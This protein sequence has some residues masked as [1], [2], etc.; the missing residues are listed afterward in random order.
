MEKKVLENFAK[1]IQ[2]KNRSWINGKLEVKNHMT[3]LYVKNDKEVIKITFPF[4]IQSELERLY[5]LAQPASFGKGQESVLDPSYRSARTLLSENFSIN[6]RPDHVL[7]NQIKELMLTNSN[8][9]EYVRAELYRVN[10]YGPGDFFKE[11]K[12]TPQAGS[13]HFGSLVFCLPS[14]FEGGVFAIR[15]LDGNEVKFDWGSTYGSSC[16]ATTMSTTTNPTNDAAAAESV[17]NSTGSSSS[18]SV[19]ANEEISCGIEYLAFASDLD[20]WIEPVTS[21]YRVTVTFHLYK[22]SL[23]EDGLSQSLLGNN[24]IVNSAEIK[25]IKELI[26]SKELKGKRVLFPVVHQYSGRSDSE[27]TLKAGDAALFQVLSNLGLNPKIMFYYDYDE[28]TDERVYPSRKRRRGYASSDDE[29][30]ENHRLTCKCYL[31]DEVDLY[32][33]DGYYEGEDSRPVEGL[34]TSYRVIW[35]RYSALD[36]QSFSVVPS[37]GNEP[38]IATYSGNVCIAT[39]W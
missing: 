9:N 6:L 17:S 37:Y 18:A 33:Y 10:I 23:P 3:T 35:A 12:D 4:P 16:K 31:T 5:N 2:D 14:E 24:N 22:E 39:T 34:A 11:H 15:E 27:V 1:F 8:T 30:D 38:S 36:S 7:L 13:G 28:D 26:A 32:S 29:E 20:H 25:A 21:G 19:T